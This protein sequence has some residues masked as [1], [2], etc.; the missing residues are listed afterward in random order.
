MALA[1]DISA[2]RLCII[3]RIHTPYEKRPNSA[4]IQDERTIES[5]VSPRMPETWNG[6][7]SCGVAGSE[8]Q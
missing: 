6:T 4:F 1:I 5:R 8:R 3:V 2:I 7:H